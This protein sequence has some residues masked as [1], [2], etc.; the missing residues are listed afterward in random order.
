MTTVDLDRLAAT[1]TEVAEAEI[2]PRWRNLD[3]G[4][5]PREDR[6]D[7]SGHCGRRSG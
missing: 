3:E 1:L 2:L 4:D 6:P 5:H 7:R